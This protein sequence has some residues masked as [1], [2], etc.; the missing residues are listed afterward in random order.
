MQ[1]CQQF[2]L[3]FEVDQTQRSEMDVS[4]H[5]LA[6]LSVTFISGQLV[7]GQSTVDNQDACSEKCKATDILL[8]QIVARLN[9]LEHSLE[10]L[11]TQAFQR[12]PLQLHRPSSGMKRVGRLVSGR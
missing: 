9:K 12:Q 6:L 10:R 2:P 11:E 5:L 4:S 3:Q 1:A 8:E 7:S